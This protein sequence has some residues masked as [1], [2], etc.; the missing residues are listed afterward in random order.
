MAT[1]FGLVA[2]ALIVWLRHRK[3]SLFG[4]FLLFF[5]L[6][7]AL[8]PVTSELTGFALLPQPN[9]FHVEMEL[10][11]LP[12]FLYLV[13]SR[14]R[15]SF[16]CGAILVFSAVQLVR[17][18]DYAALSLLP[19][20]IAT[21]SEYK[22]ANWFDRNMPNERVFA[23]GSVAI[24]MNLF[25]DTPQMG[26]CCDQGVDNFEKRIALH[27]IFTGQNAGSTDAEMSILWLKAYGVQAVAVS[28]PRSTEAF[29][30]FANPRKF[31]GVLTEMWRDAD[32]VIY[33]VPQRS[34]SLA[35]AMEP[36]SIVTRAPI[37]GLD[38]APIRAYVAALD[39]P[40][41]DAL[42]FQWTS[43]H[44]AAIA[45]N[46]GPGQVISV[47]VSYEPRWRAMVNGKA[48]S[49]RADALGLLVIEPEC[50][51]RCTVDLQFVR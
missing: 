1:A 17:F 27:T 15:N 22:I 9:R 3:S 8:A 23:P 49:T 35:H 41:L 20:D 40:Q 45:G 14:L 43:R 34:S 36:G 47:Q 25:T 46:V 31:D 12:A 18:R 10:A 13:R 51:G 11:V 33:R 30:A 2:L 39:D 7:T 19:L 4:A 28:G 29:K 26:G 6:L 21:T 32:D 42:Q 38:V 37:H 48:Q 44:S 24:W 50:N 16:V 5:A